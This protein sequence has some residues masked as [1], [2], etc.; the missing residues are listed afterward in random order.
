MVGTY[1]G[2]YPDGSKSYG[3]YADYCRAPSH[4]VIKIPDSISSADAAP[5]HCGGITAYSPLKNNGCGPG[6][7]VGIVGVGGLGHFG[8][9]YAKALGADSITAISRTSTKKSDALKLGADK[10]IATDEDPNWAK[11]HARSLDL[12]V[13]TVSSPSMPLERYLQ[14]L[15]THGQFIQVGAPEDRLPA[16]NVFSLIQKGSKIGGSAIGAPHEIEE[17][18]ELTARK[19]VKPWIQE[20]PLREANQAV[21]D[22]DEGKARYRFVLVNEGN[23]AKL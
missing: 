1:N 3:G 18:L 6:K 23:E 13:S 14:L 20:R 9:L 19:G 16:F 15:R 10:Y 22:M 17:M 2:K 21:R 7:K 5:M 11:Q 8:I 12:I 4:F